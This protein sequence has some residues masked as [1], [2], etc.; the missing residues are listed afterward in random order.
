MGNK[1]STMEKSGCLKIFWLKHVEP[2]IDLEVPLLSTNLPATETLN[3]IADT[4]YL[5]KH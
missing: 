3:T 1:K 5:H 4:C 2:N